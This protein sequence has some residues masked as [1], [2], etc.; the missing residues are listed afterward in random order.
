[1]DFAYG[2]SFCDT[3]PMLPQAKRTRKNKLLVN[4]VD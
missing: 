4:Q 1:M 3:K 2:I